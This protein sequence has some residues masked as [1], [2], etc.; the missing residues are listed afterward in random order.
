ME[1]KIM[2]D[3][4]WRAKPI[5]EHLTHALLNGLDQFIVNDIDKGRQNFHQTTTH[6]KMLHYPLCAGVVLK[7]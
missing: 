4:S 2:E 7:Y 6:E 5:S 1:S 3:L